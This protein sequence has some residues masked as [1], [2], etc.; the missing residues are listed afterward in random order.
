[1]ATEWTRQ[2]VVSDA[3]AENGLTGERL[4]NARRILDNVDTF[5]GSYV[6]SP[7]EK[8]NQGDEEEMR[9]LLY[10]SIAAKWFAQGKPA[11]GSGRV[12]RFNRGLSEKYVALL[13]M[14]PSGELD[15]HDG[16]GLPQEILSKVELPKSFEQVLTAHGGFSR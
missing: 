10:E 13:G 14:G 8:K 6:L 9:E 1:M 4:R 2:V 15:L 11:D 7:K 12:L 3:D 5:L 16:G